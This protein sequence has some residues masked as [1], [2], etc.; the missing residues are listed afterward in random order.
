MKKLFIWA[1]LIGLILSTLLAAQEKGVT[2]SVSSYNNRSI[3]IDFEHQ[4]AFIIAINRYAYLNPLK[5][6][7]KEAGQIEKILE[8]HYGYL[9]SRVKT[10]LDDKATYNT[11]MA[12]LKWYVINFTE[13][14]ICPDIFFI[15]GD[16][17]PGI[18]TGF[19]GWDVINIRSKNG[20]YYCCYNFRLSCIIRSFC[21]APF[22]T[23][24]IKL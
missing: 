8:N 4:W 1:I 19:H 9:P 5:Y 13:E 3:S 6:P 18:A 20:N 11:V 10:L 15:P 2:D 22:N 23:L 21:I 14:K 7:V 17:D 16:G 24:D 12:Q